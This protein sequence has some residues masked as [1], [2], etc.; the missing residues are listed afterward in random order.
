MKALIH[1]VRIYDDAVFEDPD[2]IVEELQEELE[3][4][5]QKGEIFN[6]VTSC[7]NSQIQG[8]EVTINFYH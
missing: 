6:I 4:L 3:R 1:P 8:I 5:D 2:Y 7:P